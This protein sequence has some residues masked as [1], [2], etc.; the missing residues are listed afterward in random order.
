MTKNL[1]LGLILAHLAQICVC[2]FYSTSNQTL[3]QAI[4]L[5]NFMQFK[6]K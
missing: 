4:I 6:G 5:C 3:F 2:T 1:I